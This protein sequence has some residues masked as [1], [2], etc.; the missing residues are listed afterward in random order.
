MDVAA[1]ELVYEHVPETDQLP[2]MVAFCTVYDSSAL[3]C[4]VIVAIT[5]CA[6]THSEQFAVAGQPPYTPATQVVAVSGM[7]TWDP[8][9]AG[10]AQDAGMLPQGLC[11]HAEHAGPAPVTCEALY[12]CQ[13]NWSGSAFRTEL[14]TSHALPPVPVP[15]V[16]TT[17]PVPPELAP[18]VLPAAPPDEAGTPPAPPLVVP[19]V[20][21][22]APPFPPVCEIEMR[23]PVLA[24]APPVAAPPAPPSS[25]NG[26]AENDEP[27]ASNASAKLSHR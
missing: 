22:L 10:C 19:P 2:L 13:V 15:P 25:A 12:D 18:P 6:V 20:D 16:D 14:A 1:S 27:Q 21:V 7:K 26:S 11:L 23:P 4:S 5:F 24:D 3:R 9:T 8:D 17:P